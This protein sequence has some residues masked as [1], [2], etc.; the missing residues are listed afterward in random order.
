MTTQ[1]ARQ[2]A[3]LTGI[4][5]RAWEHPADR[6][7]LVAL[8]RL[9]GFDT[10]LKAVSGLVNERTTRL[11]LL[12][13]A[14]RVDERQFPALHYLL[15]DA[16]RVLDVEGPLPEMYVQA[17]PTLNAV[18]IGLDK[19][20]I[21]LNSALVDLLEEDE[22]RFVVGHELGHALSGHAVYRTL[23]MRLINLTGVLGSVPLGGL[24]LRA[25]VAALYE[26]ARKSELSADRAGLLATQDPAAAIRAHMQLA[27][28]G[29]MGD[30]D[31]STFMAQGQEYLEAGDLR[32][33]VLKLMLV[34]KTTH[35]FAVV[36]AA[37]LRGW[38]DSGAYAGILG[39]DYARRD[40]DA[41]AKVSDAAKDAATSY[42]AAFEASQD[43]LGKLV[44]DLAGAAGS[45]KLWLDERLRRGE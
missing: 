38:V 28:G 35:P 4:S 9:K 45:M 26:W 12:G 15:R 19:P 30:L 41:G 5:S 36:R 17:N 20:V 34:E 8:R 7:A 21:V 16:A 40:D 6:G 39:G 3:T 1:P 31:L 2:R 24:G 32:D 14:V 43:A 25:I 27:S 23:L 10:V 37:E 44:H 33:S 18:T 13:T 22:L 11:L 42:S 29:L